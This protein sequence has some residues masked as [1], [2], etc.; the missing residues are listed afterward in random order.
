MN[1]TVIGNLT[2]TQYFNVRTDYMVA[3]TGGALCSM[4]AFACLIVAIHDPNRGNGCIAHISPGVNE[5]PVLAGMVQFLTQNGGNVN[6]FEILLA[7]AASREA[8]VGWHAAFL[9]A[10]NNAGLVAANVQD[11]RMST[12]G[13]TVIGNNAGTWRQ[14]AFEPATGQ[15]AE[16]GVGQSV[17][18]GATA[19]TTEYTISP[20][21]NVVRVPAP[22]RRTGHCAI[23]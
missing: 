11:C 8:T 9:V 10:L 12:G 5:A 13:K 20:L 2:A 14:V 23:L 7:G 1:I 18:Q 16:I 17:T 15:I 22:R 6:N 3:S 21:G 19:N 4:N